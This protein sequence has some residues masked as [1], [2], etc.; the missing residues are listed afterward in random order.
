MTTVE[1][2]GFISQI[3]SSER[4]DNYMLPRNVD[5]S[6]ATGKDMINVCFCREIFPEIKHKW[7]VRMRTLFTERKLSFHSFSPQGSLPIW[8]NKGHGLAEGD[9][10]RIKLDLQKQR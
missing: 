4:T 9:K 10:V 6:K 1:V 8:V 2:E 7:L 3:I 5:W